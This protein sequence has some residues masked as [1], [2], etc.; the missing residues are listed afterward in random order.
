MLEI[1]NVCDSL[2]DVRALQ[3]VKPH[4]SLRHVSMQ[5]NQ[6]S[7]TQRDLLNRLAPP[8]DFVANQLD[9]AGDSSNFDRLPVNQQTRRNIFLPTWQVHSNAGPWAVSFS[10]QNDNSVATSSN[11]NTTYLLAAGSLL[12]LFGAVFL[13]VLLARVVWPCFRTERLESSSSAREERGQRPQLSP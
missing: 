5:G 8:L 6:F 3:R 2:D 9:V 10:N 7:Q 13:M 11:Q 4:S 1:G 12:P